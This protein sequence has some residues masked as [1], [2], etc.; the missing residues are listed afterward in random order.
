MYETVEKKE[1]EQVPLKPFEKRISRDQANH[2]QTFRENTR[3][4]YKFF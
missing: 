2:I 1:L 4:N 3:E